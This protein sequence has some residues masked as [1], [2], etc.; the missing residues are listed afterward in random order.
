MEAHFDVNDIGKEA[1]EGKYLPIDDVFHDEMFQNSELKGVEKGD[2]SLPVSNGITKVYIAT[3]SDESSFRYEPGDLV[4]M[5]RKYTGEGPK[6]YKSAVTSYCTVTSCIHVKSNGVPLI[7]YSDY[8]HAVGNKTI[9]PDEKVK[10]LFAEKKNVFVIEMVYN[11]SFEKGNNVN[12]N[13]LEENGLWGEGHPY[14]H[15]LSG[16]DIFKI[17]RLGKANVRY[18]DIHQP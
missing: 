2:F 1:P 16:D 13:T 12:L 7:S 5:Y 17:L 18:P 8:K 11:G 4:F 3:P 9:Y 14:T 6:R 15:T 10:S